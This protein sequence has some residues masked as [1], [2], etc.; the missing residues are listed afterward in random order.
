MSMTSILM[1]FAGGFLI[2]WMISF[3]GGQPPKGGGVAVVCG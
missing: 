2:G 1:C 3:Y